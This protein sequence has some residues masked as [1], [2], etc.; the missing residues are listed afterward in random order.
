MALSYAKNDFVLYHNPSVYS[1][2]AV[3]IIEVEGWARLG[4]RPL[5]GLM[6]NNPRDYCE[7]V[8]VRPSHVFPWASAAA[9]R[10][11]VAALETAIHGRDIL[12][13]AHLTTLVEQ[14]REEG[15][16]ANAEI[17]ERIAV[18]RSFLSHLRSDL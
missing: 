14:C 7:E 2:K 9:L 3:F 12:S 4:F 11:L 8:I 16:S 10:R 17:N 1:A 6:T 13:A 18:A 15:P 5:G